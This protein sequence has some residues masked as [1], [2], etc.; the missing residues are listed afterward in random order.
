[1]VTRSSV[2]AEGKRHLS[3]PGDT[4]ATGVQLHFPFPGTQ[5]TAAA[6]VTCLTSNHF[7]GVGPEGIQPAQAKVAE[8][9]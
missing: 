2:V 6:L 7:A 8:Y 9:V 4:L 1:M 3:T 5:F